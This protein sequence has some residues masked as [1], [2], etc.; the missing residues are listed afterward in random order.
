MVGKLLR[1]WR[2][3][4]AGKSLDDVYNFELDNSP[5]NAALSIKLTEA[6]N[7]QEPTAD[8]ATNAS[9]APSKEPAPPVELDKQA[10]VVW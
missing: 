9:V 6:G 5:N 8:V 3:K 1:P 4:D 10:R 2:E 7:S